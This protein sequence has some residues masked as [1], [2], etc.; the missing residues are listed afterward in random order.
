MRKLLLIVIAIIC[1]CKQTIAAD[2]GNIVFY[3]R[4]QPSLASQWNSVDKIKSSSGVNIYFPERKGN[5]DNDIK[6]YPLVIFMPTDSKR[7]FSYVD[8]GLSNTQIDL[9]AAAKLKIELRVEI[10]KV[11]ELIAGGYT[12]ESIGLSCTNIKDYDFKKNK[13]EW[14]SKVDIRFYIESSE[15]ND[16]I[17]YTD[18]EKEYFK[19]EIPLEP[20]TSEWKEHSGKIEFE[21]YYENSYFS[22]FVIRN[23]SA[24]P[25]YLHIG[26]TI[27]LKDIIIPVLSNGSPAGGYTNYSWL[28]NGADTIGLGNMQIYEGDIEYKIALIFSAINKED[29]AYY[30]R[31]QKDTYGPPEAVSFTI[32]SFY[33]NHFKFKIDSF[34][35]FNLTTDFV[36]DRNCKIPNEEEVNILIDVRSLVYSDSFQLMTNDITGYYL[37][38]FTDKEHTKSELL[39]QSS[40][41]SYV[42]NLISK[43]Y[44]YSI[45]LHCIYPTDLSSYTV[46]DYDP[47]S[48]D[49]C[50]ISMHDHKDWKNK[51]YVWPAVI[52][53]VDT[54][55]K[56]AINTIDDTDLK[57]ESYLPDLFNTKEECE[58]GLKIIRYIFRNNKIRD[59]Y[60]CENNNL[61]LDI[62]EKF[63]DNINEKFKDIF[64]P[65]INILTIINNE[66]LN[67]KIPD[68]LGSIST[69]QE[70][71]LKNNNFCEDI[72][73]SLGQLKNL[74]YYECNYSRTNICYKNSGIDFCTTGSDICKDDFSPENN[75]NSSSINYQKPYT[76]FHIIVLFVLSLFL[77]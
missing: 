29:F 16:S 28:L 63:T 76:L 68:I 65:Q 71:N 44:F 47:Q 49:H 12:C 26:N 45:N 46:V 11:E 8:F 19:L 75:I 69:L 64:L 61:K 77:F 57:D 58:D 59:N 42:D 62:D 30:A 17:D 22:N 48:S 35:E 39:K 24:L 15:I 70:I 41:P 43:V 1:L 2:I 73:S 9:L 50:D 3:G 21:N 4:G 37:Q 10:P 27:F 18:D 31:I 5:Q 23:F 13:S 51:D 74:K 34:K 53:S 55:Y 38:A 52:N 33:V 7:G 54:L 32:R 6:N 20:L 67:C 66:K 72:P 60:S 25:I 36:L 14:L 40:D 56:I